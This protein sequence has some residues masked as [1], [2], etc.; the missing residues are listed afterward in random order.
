M[1]GK[2]SWNSFLEVLGI[3]L[4]AEGSQFSSFHWIGFIL[5]FHLLPFCLSDPVSQGPFLN[6]YISTCSPVKIL[7][8]LWLFL[9]CLCCHLLTKLQTD[10]C[11]LPKIHLSLCQR[12]RRERL[13]LNIANWPSYTISPDCLQVLFFI[14][15]V[16]PTLKF[17]RFS[18]KDLI[19]PA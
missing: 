19:C 9:R 11:L 5:P 16:L 1:A 12:E 13:F 7:D 2:G 15:L 14:T 10:V 18:L 6:P 4:Y 8:C 3:H 17:I